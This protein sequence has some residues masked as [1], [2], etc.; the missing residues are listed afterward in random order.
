MDP[1][2]KQANPRL[3]SAEFSPFGAEYGRA[4]GLNIE[5]PDP[6]PVKRM[7]ENGQ[8]VYRAMWRQEPR[9][10]GAIG[11]RT[12]TL[13]TAGWRIVPGESKSKNAEDLAEWCRHYLGSIE[14]FN[15]VLAKMLESVH[16][17][18]T[19]INKIWGWR[20]WRG[21]DYYAPHK[22]IDKDRLQFG[23]A[24]DRNLVFKGNATYRRQ[25]FSTP[26]QA[27]R[28]M[29][30]TYG[31]QDNPYGDKF[32][33]QGAWVSWYLKSR[34]ME[35]FSAGMSRSAGFLAM[36]EDIASRAAGTMARDG[37]GNEASMADLE[38]DLRDALA[39][40][41]T[42][43]ILISRHGYKLRLV[44]DQ[45]FSLGWIAA[46]EYLDRQI[47]MSIVGQTL[48]SD[49]QGEGSRAAA[50]THDTKLVSLC[51]MDGQWLEGQVKN[52]LIRPALDWN[53]SGVDDDDRPIFQMMLDR[54]PSLAAF[55]LA[56][57]HL[58]FQVDADAFEAATN[59]VIA[60]DQ[61]G[62]PLFAGQG[63]S[64]SDAPPTEAEEDPQ[65]PDNAEDEEEEEPTD[66]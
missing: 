25:A 5:V 17:G 8:F 2:P 37:K 28:W 57:E 3:T 61:N 58:G 27:A 11:Q 41:D 49:L 19:P 53:F 6:D 24:P 30:C 44:T 66:E 1:E 12:S 33:L 9:I 20:S 52:E 32:T 50:E 22:L 40:L 15:G 14:H 34:T 64:D 36:E 47:L 63:T 45:D 43:G 42:E 35:M 10:Q 55:Q 59:V 65:A 7:D 23:F 54:E 51:K 4:G 60:R 21:R 26:R 48:T 16:F 31:T 62:E 56:T 18:F 39:R 46:L 13:L 38:K 29:R